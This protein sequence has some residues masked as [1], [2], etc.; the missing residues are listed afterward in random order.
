[1]EPMT[2]KAPP[3]K[4][5]QGIGLIVAALVLL[6]V[7]IVRSTPAHAASS[8]RI[9]SLAPAITEMVYALG[10]DPELVGVTSYCNYPPAAL[11]KPR[12]GNALDLNEE[13]VVSLKPELI[14]ATEGDKG[15][16]ERLGKLTHAR[17]L[18]LPTKHVADIWSNM[19]T[20]GKLTGTQARAEKEVKSLQ[21]R[22]KAAA[23]RATK[24]HPSV[25]YMVWDKP[26]MTAGGDSYL[27][28]LI[29][30]AGGK[31]VAAVSAGGSYPGYSWEA[32][33]AQNPQVI[34]GP[35]NMASALKSLKRQYP[36]LQAVKGDR[37]RTVPDDLISRPGPRVVQALE[38]V[39][40]AL[41]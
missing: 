28:D 17:V 1:M 20:I 32:L 9:L 3:F 11:K 38:A 34:L 23:A 39:E 5:R 6:L 27:N 19:R 12:V 25:F 10:L 2:F 13:L 40:A 31:N 37:L 18:V 33:L 36:S 26:L 14:L 22:L 24:A 15:R 35:Q 29:A 21:A 8:P 16:L 7:L 30:L 4:C 41:R